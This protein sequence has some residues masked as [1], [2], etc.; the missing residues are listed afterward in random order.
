MALLYV[1]S[2]VKNTVRVLLLVVEILMFCRAIV[3]WLPVNEDSALVRFL[4]GTT[5]IFITPV[6]VLFDKFGW[7][8]GFPLDMPFFFTFMVIILIRIFL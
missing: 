4:V 6:R 7:F 3:S 5:E 1:L 8:E 2:L